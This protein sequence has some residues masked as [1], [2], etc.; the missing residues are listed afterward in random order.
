MT[1]FSCDTEIVGWEVEDDSFIENYRHGYLCAF[2]SEKM[3]RMGIKPKVRQGRGCLLGVDSEEEKDVGSSL[4]IDENPKRGKKECHLNMVDEKVRFDTFIKYNWPRSMKQRPDKLASAGFFYGGKFD[5][6]T[7][8][9]CGIQ[10]F[11]WDESDDCFLEHYK[12]A[13]LMCDFIIERMIH[14]DRGVFKPKFRVLQ[15]CFCGVDETDS[16]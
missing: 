15:S 6:V 3:A 13:A 10:L 8:F 1:C 4:S 9:S 7:C 14:D 12:H 5:S 16:V 11:D 2:I